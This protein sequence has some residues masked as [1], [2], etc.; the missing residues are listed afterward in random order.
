[1]WL[2]PQE[3][4][5]AGVGSFAIRSSFCRRLGLGFI[6]VSF[7]ARGPAVEVHAD[8]GPYVPRKVPRRKTAL[9]R[10]FS[11]RV[12]DPNTGGQTRR[13]VITA[14]RQDALRIAC[15]LSENPGDSPRAI[16][17]ATAVFKAG[18]ILV[19]NHYGWFQRA[20]RGSYE[21]T[22]NGRGALDQYRDVVAEI[23]EATTETVQ[24]A[25]E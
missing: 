15:H 11:R 20:A 17:R 2:C 23:A 13:A 16:V 10:E 21:L 6:S 4:A 24:A 3:K 22:E 1:M 8:P 9:L 19:K 14:Y 25:A 18:A 12:G 5:R 7:G